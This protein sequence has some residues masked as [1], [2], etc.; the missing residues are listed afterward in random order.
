MSAAAPFY[1][2]LRALGFEDA[3][4]LPQ[5]A[6]PV[7]PGPW[8]RALA[9]VLLPGAPVLPDVTAV[10]EPPPEGRWSR[11]AEELAPGF[12]AL[13]DF[14]PRSSSAPDASGAHLLR[15]ERVMA[16]CR[17]AARPDAGDVL[18]VTDWLAPAD[19]PELAAALL[20]AALAAASGQGA[21]R[22]AVETPHAGLGA[23]LQ[24][25]R[26]LPGRSRA[27]ILMR[28][29]SRDEPIPRTD[30]WHFSTRSQLKLPPPLV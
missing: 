20:R 25:A 3:G 8:R 17:F 30:A 16:A 23:G 28:P 26:F 12:G 11:L 24:I 29:A 22:V 7:R 10:P 9:F 18:R 2:D 1:R 6:A 4:P 19:E 21:R 13:S 15:G 5:Y 27:R 14:G